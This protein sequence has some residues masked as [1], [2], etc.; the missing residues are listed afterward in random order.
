M[1]FFVTG[2]EL[3]ED[4]LALEIG[5]V[6]PINSKTSGSATTSGPGLYH[7]GRPVFTQWVPKVLMP[8]R[9]A[10]FMVPPFLVIN[11]SRELII[12]TDLDMLYFTKHPV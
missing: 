9:N 3:L 1:E 2:Q 10:R 8:G 11:K 4:K 12:L 7:S 6:K 5:K